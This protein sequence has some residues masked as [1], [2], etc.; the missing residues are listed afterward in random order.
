MRIDKISKKKLKSMVIYGFTGETCK[1]CKKTANVP[2]IVSW[3]C[4]CGSRNLID[5][6]RKNKIWDN[7]DYGLNEKE[8]INL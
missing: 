3:K 8:I 4:A 1:V 6:F 7:P 5:P 2:F